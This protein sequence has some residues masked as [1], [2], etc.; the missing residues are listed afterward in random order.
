MSRVW[1]GCIERQAFEC[2]GSAKWDEMAARLPP[3]RKN[4]LTL[5]RC[6]FWEGRRRI[7]EFV[8]CRAVRETASLVVGVCVWV[9]KSGSLSTVGFISFELRMPKWHGNRC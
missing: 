7:R 1:W 3:Q 8:N 6:R 9:E 4:V 5:I 2:A